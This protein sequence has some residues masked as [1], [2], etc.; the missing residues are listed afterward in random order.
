[1]PLITISG[2]CVDFPKEPYPVQLDYMEC[3]INA[4]RKKSN[5]MLES[6]TGTGKTLMLLCATLAWQSTQ[7]VETGNNVEHKKI[8]EV[9]IYP[10]KGS[11]A[12]KSVIIY[13]SRT[14]SQLTQVVGE[15]KSTSYRPKMTVVGSREQLCVHPRISHLKGG[16][17]N[18]A[19][20]SLTSK[21][22]CSFKNKLSNYSSADSFRTMD[23]EDMVSLGKDDSICPYFFA[24]DKS[25]ESDIIFLPYNYLLDSSI[26]K[27]LKI[28]WNNSVVIFDEAHNLERVAADAASVSFNSTDIATCITELKQ[29]A[30]ILNAENQQ[31]K[32]AN[33]EN[34]TNEGNKSYRDGISNDFQF[35]SLQ[36]PTLSVV[37][38]LLGAMFSLE[39]LIE[40][41]TLMNGGIIPGK[42]NEFPGIW[43]INT[44]IAAGF[45][46]SSMALTHIEE[47]RRSSDLLIEETQNVLGV[48]LSGGA[49][50]SISEP[51]LVLFACAYERVFRSL[52]SQ[53]IDYKTFISEEDIPPK[54]GF[55]NSFTRVGKKRIV[56]FW[57][58]CS[59]IAMEEL[60]GLGV[61]S[62]ILTSGTLS[63]MN[64]MREDMKLPFP[65]QLE[66]P[67]VIGNSQIWVGA[68]KVGPNGIQLNS[69]FANRDND[70]YKDE[71]GQTILQISA[72]MLG[73]TSVYG[74][75]GI[76]AGQELRGGILVFFQSYAAM[77]SMIKRWT[78]N[79]IY[80][81]IKSI[82]GAIVV[83][84]KSTTNHQTKNN[85][86]FDSTQYKNNKNDYNESK[87]KTKQIFDDYESNGFDSAQQVLTGVMQEFE[88]NLS[89]FGSCILMAV[90]RG[91]VS[92]GIDFTDQKGRVVIIT[93][94]P[95]APQMDP[96][97]ILKKKYLD[98]K[99]FVNPNANSSI[100][101]N[102]IMIPT[103]ING[104]DK[105]LGSMPITVDNIWSDAMKSIH[106]N[107]GEL[108]GSN[109]SLQNVSSSLLQSSAVTM[110]LNNNGFQYQ[111]SNSSFAPNNN[112][113]PRPETSVDNIS[114]GMKLTGQSWYLQSASRAVNQCLGRVIRHKKDWGAIFLLDDRFLVDK[115]KQQLSRWIRPKVKNYSVFQQ[116][117]NDFRQFITIAMN[118]KN[119]EL[120]MIDQPFDGTAI[121][122]NAVRRAELLANNNNNEMNKG[123]DIMI[124]RRLEISESDLNHNDGTFINPSLLL[125]QNNKNNYNTYNNNGSYN[126]NKDDGE[127]LM[128]NI[129][130]NNHQN[131]KLTQ[132]TLHNSNNDNA[133]I[134]NN[135]NNNNLDTIFDR[136]KRVNGITTDSKLSSLYPQS[137][138]QAVNNQHNLNENKSNYHNENNYNLSQ[139]SQPLIQSLSQSQSQLNNKSQLKADKKLFGIS[140]NPVQSL[141]GN[142][143]W[144]VKT[145]T[146]A[147][148][149]IKPSII[150]NN[151][152]IVDQNNP[153]EEFDHEYN[154]EDLKEMIGKLKLLLEKEKFLILKGIVLNAKKSQFNLI[155]EVKQ[156]IDQLL[157]VFDGLET[158]FRREVMLCMG[159]LVSSKDLI[160]SYYSLVRSA[161]RN[162][163]STSINTNNNNDQ[164]IN[165]ITNNNDI[166]IKNK[167][168]IPDSWAILSHSQSIFSANNIILSNNTTNNNSTSGSLSQQTKK[169][170]YD[171]ND[172]S[173]GE[174]GITKGSK[175]AKLMIASLNNPSLNS[176]KLP[177]TS[178]QRKELLL[179]SNNNND[180]ENNNN[181][182]TKEVAT[183]S[184][185]NDL[186]KRLNSLGSLEL[187][188]VT[189]ENVNEH[190]SSQ[191]LAPNPKLVCIICIEPALHPCAA[192]CGHVCCRIC[193][194]TWLKV[195]QTCP[196]CRV[197]VSMDSLT[198]IVVIEK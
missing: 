88:H 191:L 184:K 100:Q 65:I 118:D 31:R 181:N 115:Q 162:H 78:D 76:P 163:Q 172:D 16:M 101:H 138:I 87:N 179:N 19:C 195:N 13:A 74:L 15:L 47:L 53:A 159:Q 174:E 190:N 37:T 86:S 22:G 177:L 103:Q 104:N 24:R 121:I 112:V 58:F 111:K 141:S 90:S 59:G 55:S 132:E 27:T 44:F 89:V 156:F 188:G 170:Y 29:V 126:R 157:E 80:N 71:L 42:S 193:W 102:K 73:K 161:I 133:N 117:L 6:P 94:I 146:D 149:D 2:L 178:T 79:G 25:E 7:I 70:K 99:C 48:G 30:R 96:W 148:P 69:A 33:E 158:S 110:P 66:N 164:K 56:N 61:R 189:K 142:S 198:K 122:H 171:D 120:K 5:A 194:M 43:L 134:R 12:G 196:T 45:Q 8:G 83:E 145:V 41:A 166:I 144:E 50:V 185:S 9:K 34:K 131:K 136:S 183:I 11:F 169:K 54:P 106:S 187:K 28:E 176:N 150:N 116:V 114:S 21:G 81:K 151:N 85:K 52:S 186:I 130:Q 137:N 68:V 62:I 10:M 108:S 23:I 160:Q 46:M 36:R 175:R 60:K 97:I 4:L 77:E 113:I 155:S 35:S 125:T 119:L 40:N 140:S 91:K 105:M 143:S 182:K 127:L 93:G 147:K 168:N 98:E 72:T 64:A 1:M 26:R 165:I 57:A 38:H 32:G 18:H 167:P 128:L 3:V 95:Y 192:K 14:H 63:P 135:G 107:G 152:E 123:N 82:V 51:K 173:E 39:K 109:V 20:T 153:F 124:T 92:E 67:H 75:K 129:I 17:L 49:P 154:R 197:T 180:N 139:L 84:P